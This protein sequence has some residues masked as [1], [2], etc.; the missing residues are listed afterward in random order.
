MSV[1]PELGKAAVRWGLFV[2]LLAG[3]LLLFEP[4]GSAQFYVAAFT[5]AIG[6]AFVSVV[7][8]LVRHFSR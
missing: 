1:D 3:G 6:L 4:A 5:L 2:V 7:V 8:F